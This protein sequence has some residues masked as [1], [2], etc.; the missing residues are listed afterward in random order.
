LSLGETGFVD[1]D[2]GLPN[3]WEIHMSRRMAAFIAVLLL[4]SPGAHADSAPRGQSRELSLSVAGTTRWTTV[5]QPPGYQPGAPL[6]LLLHGGGQGMRKIFSDKAGGMRQWLHI[7]DRENFLLLIPNATHAR[8]G[9]SRGD[10]QNWNDLRAAG[11]TGKTTA[12]DVGFLMQLLDWAQAQYRTDANRV[13]VTGASNGGMM[14]MR[15]LLERPQRFR[16]AAAFIASLPAVAPPK[17]R[18]GARVPLLLFNGT[19]DPLIQWHGGEIRGE[20]AI[21]A[22]RHRGPRLDPIGERGK[23][24]AIEPMVQW[25]REVNGVEHAPAT[26]DSV[27]D[28]DPSDGCRIHRS[29]WRAATPGAAT[30]VFFRAEGGGHALPSIE[31]PLNLGPVARRLIGPVCRDV[32]GAEL[33]WEFFRRYGTRQGP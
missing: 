14:T 15:L 19:Q 28:R 17:P 21:G 22:S 23:T 10:K 3:P 6:V 7:A 5:Y 12:D 2:H 18:A 13:F 1:G 26:D 8:T 9:D 24:M 4:A 33:A 32:E 30:V 25:W 27:P 20:S 16:A 29:E 11:T 31:H